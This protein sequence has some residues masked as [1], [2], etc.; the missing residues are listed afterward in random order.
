MGRPSKS[1]GAGDTSTTATTDVVG[2]WSS[3]PVNLSFHAGS[4]APSDRPSRPAAAEG[5]R[6]GD[7]TAQQP[8]ST[9]DRCPL[10]SR[11]RLSTCVNVLRQLQSSSVCDA[12]QTST[13]WSTVNRPRLP[14]DVIADLRVK[15]ARHV[16]VLCPARTAQ[17]ST[18]G[19]RVSAE[20]LA[21]WRWSPKAEE[22]SETCLAAAATVYDTAVG[23]P[24]VT[25]S[26]RRDSVDDDDDEGDCG[27]LMPPQPPAPLNTS[28]DMPARHRP[29][30]LA[31][32]KQTGS[33]RLS[34]CIRL[35]IDTLIASILVLLFARSEA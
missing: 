13:L 25:S 2:A 14:A 33:L 8:D 17:L 5:P 19:T 34:S 28:A 35:A 23:S 27:S 3:F 11:K 21:R 9:A 18:L 15:R 1:R 6:S 16:G 32:R 24:S 22:H 31:D 30:S 26:G 10:T 20:Q 7:A 4:A 12:K 29:R